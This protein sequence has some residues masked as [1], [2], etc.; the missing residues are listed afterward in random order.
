[1]E[2]KLVV[3]LLLFVVLNFIVT[4]KVVIRTDLERVQKIGQIILVWLLPVFGAVGIWLFY[5]SV[6]KSI[7]KPQSFAK[8][9]EGSNSW[10]DT[11]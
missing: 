3:I 9:S 2:T 7:I 6:D 1:M 10:Q 5:R 11:P 8:R 4:F